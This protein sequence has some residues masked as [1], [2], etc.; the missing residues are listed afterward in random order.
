MLSRQ[1][2]KNKK[3]TKKTNRENKPS[4][5]TSIFWFFMPKK[6]K[7]KGL[8]RKRHLSDRGFMT[9]FNYRFDKNFDAPGFSF[10]EY[11]DDQDYKKKVLGI[12]YYFS[13]FFSK[14]FERVI[15]FFRGFFRL[16]G[17]ISWKVS[18][19][20]LAVVLVSVMT[21]F[22]SAAPESVTLTTQTEWEAGELND[23]SST[24]ETDAIQLASDGTWTARSWSPAPDSIYFGSTSALVGNYLYV[25]RGY[26]DDDLF[27]YNIELNEW[28]ESINLPAPAHYGCDVE[29]DGGGNLYFTF[30]GYS[31]KF[32]K[33]NIENEEWTELPDLLD[34]IYQGSGIAFDGTDFFIMKG[35]AST[36]FWRFDVSEN[37]WYNL[38][39]TPSTVYRGAN[40]IYGENGNMYL[41]RGYNQRT[42]WEYDIS[43]NSW[44]TMTNAPASF[45]D[46]QKGVL[47]NG[48]LYFLRANNTTTF[49]RYN[50]SGN[51]WDTLDN[52]PASVR[53]G[54]ITYNSDDGHMYAIRANGQRTLWKFDPD[55]GTTGEW[56]GPEYAPGTVNTGGDLIWNK[57][58][59]AGNYV[60]AIRGDG[61]NAFYRYDVT[62][63]SWGTMT[64]LPATMA[65]DTKGTYHNGYIYVHRGDNTTTSFYRYDVSGNSWSTMAAAPA[66]IRYGSSAAYAQDGGTDYVYMTRG[67]AQPDFYRYNISGDSW[68]T[69]NDIITADGTSYR[70]YYGS[71]LE[72]DGT[73]LYLMPGDGETAFLKYD[74]S[75][76]SWSDLTR[77]PFVQRLGTDMTYRDGKIYA[78]A[79]Y[80]KDETWEYTISTDSWRKLPLNQKYTY[81]RGPSNGASMV[82]AGGDSFYASPGTDL[83]DFWSYTLGTNN[84]VSSGTHVSNAID[85]AYVNSWISLTG[86]EDTPTN[87]TVTYETRTSSDAETWSSWQALSGSS[88]QSPENRYIQVRS[89]LATSDGVSTPTVYDYTISYNSEDADPTNPDS[90]TAKSQQ[91]GGDTLVSETAYKHAHPYFS[92]SGAGDS[93]SGIEGYY[94]YFGT[95]DDADPETAGAFQTGTTYTVNL[96]MGTGNYYLRIKTKDEDGNVAD[97]A[98]DAFTYNYDSVSPHQSATKT[99]EADF[100][101]GTVDQVSTSSD[102]DELQLEGTDGFWGQ[103]RLSNTPARM[104][105]GAE[106]ANASGDLYALRG[107]NQDDFYHYDIETGVWSSLSDTPENVYYGGSLVEGPSGYLYASRGYNTPTFWRYDIAQDLWEVM[108]SAPKNF[109][110]GSSLSF[111]ENRYVYAIPGNDDAFYRYDTQSNQWTTLPNAEFGNP[112]E[113]DGQRTSRGSDSAYDGVNAIY[114]LQGNYYPYFA[115]YTI[116][117]NDDRGESANEWVPLAQAPVGPYTGG[118]MAY[119]PETDSIFIATGNYRRNFYKYD[120]STDTWT[121]LQDTPSAVEY[122]GSMDVID[123]YIYTLRGYNSTLFYRFNIEENS[124]E[125]PTQ[126]FF[127]PNNP[128]TATTY[129]DFYYGA[130]ME[131]DD[132]GNIYITRGYYSDDF[133][134]Y[135]S[136]TGEFTRLARL[137]VGV[138]QGAAMVFNEDEN[139]LYLTAGEIRTRKSGT[140]NNYFMKYTVATN[141]WEIITA[142]PAP[143]QTG[144]G[145]SMV[146]DGSR[147][148]YLTRGSNSNWWWRYDTQAVAGSRWSSTLPTISGWTQG[149]GGQITYKEEGSN[150]YIYSTRGTNTNTFW[151]YDID[152]TSWL[153]LANVPATVRYGGALMDGNDGYLYVTRGNNTD[154]Y[155]R[156]DISGNSWETLDDVPGQIYTGGAGAFTANRVWAIAGHGT[157][158]F[159]DGLYNYLVSSP[160]N[161]TGF[162][163]TGSYTSE[164]INLT[165]VYRWANLTVNYTEPENTSLS[166]YTRTSPDAAEWSSWDQVT[167]EKELGSMEH[168]YSIQSAADQY[169]QIKIDF[170]SADQIYSPSVEDYTINYYQDL[171]APTNPSSIE[172][173]DT[174]SMENSIT[175]NTWYN[176]AAPHFVWPVA[177]E[178]GGATDGSG[179]SGVVGYY[180]Y[181]GTDSGADPFVDGDYQTENTFTASSLTSGE[182]YYLLIKAIDDAEIVPT[183]SYQA[184]T[185]RFDN[186]SPSN[187]SEIL[188]DPAGFTATDSY[189]FT[190]EADAAD[191]DSGLD[192]FQYR[193]G[194]D[195]ENTW[196]DLDSGEVEL[197]I[198]NAEHVV[199][200]YQSGKN[201]FYL[202]TV[203]NAGNASDTLDQEYYFSEDAPSP[204]RNLTVD[205]ETSVSNSFAFEWEQPESF[206]GN[207]NELTYHYSINALPNAYNT[208]ETSLTAAGPGPFAT[209]KG[210]NR[211]YVVAMDEA[212]NIDYDLYAY[213][214]FEANTTA[215]GAPTNIQIFD[216]SDRENEEYSIAI[217]WTAPG[218]MDEE[219]F[220]GY[221]IYRSEDNESFEEVATTSGSA[222]VDTELESK[223]YYYYVK[224]KDNTNNLSI[225]SS[226]VNIIPTGRYTKPPTLVTEPSVTVQAY[227]ADFTWSTN[228]VSSSFVE[229]G[230]AMSLGKTNGQVDSVT[231]HAVE[232]TGLDAG[233]KYFYRVKY[234]DPDGN[235]GTSDIGTFETLPPPTISDVVINDIG[236]ETATISWTT[237]TSAKCTLKYGQGN[238]DNSIEE[239]SSGSS[240][241]IKLIGLVSSTG[242]KFQ[243]DAIDDD[244]NEFSS[245]EYTFTTLEQPIVS[246]LVVE[247]KENVD[248]PTVVVKYNTS[249]ATT[250]LVKFK[251]GDEASH[252]NNLDNEYKTEHQVELEGLEPSVEYEIIASGVD[253]NGIEAASLQANITTRSDSRPPGILTN[254]SVGRV[255]GRGQDA[256][257]NMYVRVE[258]DEVTRVKI[259]YGKGIVASN[260]E[261]TSPES[262]FNTYHMITIPVDPGQVYS[263]VAKAYDEAENVTSTNTATVVVEASKAN[264]S[265]IVVNTFSSKFGWIGKLWQ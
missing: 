258:T 84:F 39:P 231:S 18:I 141:S 222:Y 153:Q 20:L 245:D 75:D 106:L 122:G 56:I 115:K 226:E 235:I 140:V 186:S 205:P 169:I 138:Y 185:Y 42:L 49:Y 189:A 234:I 113:G 170:T 100:E 88:I 110:Y 78:M 174:V 131:E 203:D 246:D 211:F 158:T 225:A 230:K 182:D 178:T 256:R 105:Y 259:F 184:F 95:E 41:L 130:E 212:E 37:S 4:F 29:Y 135:N 249:L 215:P 77:S 79:G 19:V 73:D 157:N 200:A 53:S 1:K 206:M 102:P 152:D 22:S 34:T 13:W 168:R 238:Y 224:A 124:W 255:I 46:E 244:L 103:V 183:G 71:R 99:S 119:D 207:E 80:Y 85:L 92:W 176:H 111:D 21:P 181:F 233:S 51:S 216:T 65:Y 94:V 208:V 125:T 24:S 14:L 137:P 232:V 11:L 91:I 167:Q 93:G 237:N 188:V 117:D 156:Y 192:K 3:K 97:S 228:R 55:A 66:T 27:V 239:T 127:G 248:L 194:G 23:I 86:T 60:Y 217:K 144:Y 76:D 195:D 126:G 69:M 240:H 204:P 252:H 243:V 159:Y 70:A 5:L 254:R 155:Y 196:V 15:K 221:V 133:G 104:R 107:N 8:D 197:T 36:D 202:R 180:V 177:E 16:L 236:L 262:S 136:A 241:V 172:A 154:D 35:Q 179:G 160:S 190:W 265:E 129:F 220:A 89:T 6:W 128:T 9:V 151:R 50:I 165:D 45:Y 2:N 209:Q 214:D 68:D 17:W 30:G 253:E 63:N 199:G 121:Q 147:Y 229:Y 26:S 28:E 149:Q 201:W 162:V 134:K 44:S 54:S 143:Y 210:G 62:N 139:V 161:D 227:Q 242:Y 260:F 118:C 146:Y 261:Q 96:A 109:Y 251:K 48:Y 148:I 40:I 81:G 67:N 31:K 264:A 12:S 32:Y 171:D 43:E 257:A 83:T 7:K 163:K 38:A 58:T 59:G 263:Y 90:I 112:N 72:S 87:T 250:S 198:P 187:P 191:D 219:N 61:N 213:V 150:H 64:S 98:W 114:A 173:Y 57:A 82:Y 164:A 193:T 33:Y 108:S 175:T 223:R 116:D 123:G 10:K 218:A 101:A 166:I 142:D 132:Q 145:S 52:A 47:Y 247:N 120:V 74:V 25:V